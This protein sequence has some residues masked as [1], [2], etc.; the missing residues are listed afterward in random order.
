M[1]FSFFA[2]SRKLLTFSSIAVSVIN[3]LKESKNTLSFEHLLQT[4]FGR[5]NYTMYFDIRQILHIFA[6][7]SRSFLSQT[8]VLLLSPSDFSFPA[9]MIP[10][11]YVCH[12]ERSEG[13]YYIG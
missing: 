2:L 11:L 3:S 5:V 10:W 8:Y 7:Q 4:P 13:S 12:P 1:S 6:R 9:D